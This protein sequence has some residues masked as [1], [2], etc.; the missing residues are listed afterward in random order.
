MIIQKS[1]CIITLLWN[2]ASESASLSWNA[3]VSRAVTNQGVRANNNAFKPQRQTAKIHSQR[4][5]SSEFA[6]NASTKMAQCL[7]PHKNTNKYTSVFANKVK[8][9]WFVNVY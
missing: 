3:N 4:Y 7:C 1:R 5:T 2:V 9:S 6:E 8:V